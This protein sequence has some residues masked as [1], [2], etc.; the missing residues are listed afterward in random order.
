MYLTKTPKFV[1]EFFP[2]LLWDMPREQKN[3][4]LTFDDGPHPEITPLVLEMLEQYN[5]RATFFCV[6]ENI[7]KYSD[8]FQMVIDQGHSVG[9]HTYNHLN[10]WATENPEYF[11]NVRK[12]AS[13]AG[14]HLFRPP[15]GRIKPS[16]AKFLVRYYQ[17]VMWD[18]LSG[19]FDRSITGEQCWDKIKHYTEP[20]SIVVFHDSE[21]ARERMLYALPR[22]LDYYSQRG[23]QFL[24]INQT[25]KP[26]AK[27]V[28]MHS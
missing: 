22:M 9:S 13:M 11:K 5:A 16:Q 1:K 26:P 18:V 14:S 19:D 23:Y 24:A 4:Y 28:L 3:I 10:G 15:Y 8:V 21:K 17:I 20:G 12:A 25:I 6:G 7:L 2:G 27:P